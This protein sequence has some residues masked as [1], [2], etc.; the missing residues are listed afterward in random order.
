[1]LV[2]GRKVNQSIVI[3]P[4]GIRITITGAAQG[5]IVRIGIEAPPEF[6]VL[7]EELIGKYGKLQAEA[8]REEQRRKEGA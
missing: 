4:G 7:R 6:T 5:G 2:L 3:E 1:M 8:E